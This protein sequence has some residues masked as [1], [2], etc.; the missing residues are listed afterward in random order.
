MRRISWLA[1]NRLASQEGL[2]CTEYAVFRTDRY[3]QRPVK[4]YQTP[5][6]P[7]I[8]GS[9]EGN[10]VISSWISAENSLKEPDRSTDK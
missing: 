6:V 7:Q 8:N 10:R 2:C 1:E 5:N 3:E 4:K 9:T